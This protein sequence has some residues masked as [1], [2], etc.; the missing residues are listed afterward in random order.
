MLV[1]SILRSRSLSLSLVPLALEI[2]VG[3]VNAFIVA[4][5]ELVRT[6]LMLQFGRAPEGPSSL[7]GPIDCVRQVVRRHGVLGMWQAS[8]S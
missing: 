7:R 3:T 2:G 5:V 1:I 4:P 8:D 6:K